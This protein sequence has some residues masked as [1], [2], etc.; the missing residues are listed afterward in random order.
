M[1]VHKRKMTRSL[2]FLT[3]FAADEYTYIHRESKLFHQ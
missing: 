1:G 3:S 2:F